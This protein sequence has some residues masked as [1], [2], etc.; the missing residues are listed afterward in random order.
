MNLI[1][2]PF[3]GSGTTAIVAIAN[4][5]TFIGFEINE[6]Y[7]A[8]AKKRITKQVTED[9]NE[10]RGYISLSVLQTGKLPDGSDLPGGITGPFKLSARH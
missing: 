6:V 7:C 8:I 1:L 5:K 3:L 9:I 10:E 2:D 4:G